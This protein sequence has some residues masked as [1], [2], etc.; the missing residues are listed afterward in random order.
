MENLKNNNIGNFGVVD[1]IDSLKKKIS[2]SRLFI[3][4]SALSLLFVF[5]SVRTDSG[6]LPGLITVF[7]ST[8]CAL[9]AYSST[10]VLKPG[11]LSLLVPAVS[12]IAVL[13]GTKDIATIILTLSFIPAGLT[14]GFSVKTKKT[15]M[16]SV[17]Y[18]GLIMAFVIFAIL[19][20]QLYNYKGAITYDNFHDT[21]IEVATAYVRNYLMPLT[22]FNEVFKEISPVDA[23]SDTIKS[24]LAAFVLLV[25]FIQ[26]YISGSVLKNI[27][28]RIGLEEE[29]F[30]CDN[31]WKLL[32]SKIAAAVFIIASILFSTFQNFFNVGLIAPVITVLYPLGAG[33]A[34]IGLKSFYVFLKKSKMFSYVIFMLI[35][36]GTSIFSMV[37]VLLIFVG[38]LKTL[39][40]GTKIDFFKKTEQ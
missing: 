14:L 19:G 38:L 12:L 15:R 28:K 5:I 11:L 40:R 34:I 26:A 37:I 7:L 6:S 32:M 21:V 18:V 39:L 36:F 31:K 20:Y 16:Q 22:N 17:T 25:G 24:F 13:F 2:K 1:E 9:I 33:L 10:V 30:G 27:F 3:F 23:T 29:I 4:F 8:T 35:L